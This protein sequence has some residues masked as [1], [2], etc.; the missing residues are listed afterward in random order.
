MKIDNA[1]NLRMKEFQSF[2]DRSLKK[3][4]LTKL[5]EKKMESAKVIGLLRSIQDL[6]YLDNSVIAQINDVAY[7]AVQTNQL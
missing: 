7:K 2:K 5:M 4:L 6:S 1:L 3:E